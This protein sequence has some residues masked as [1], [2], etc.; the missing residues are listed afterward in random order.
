MQLLSGT[1]ADERNSLVKG[2]SSEVIPEG[3]NHPATEYKKEATDFLK[4]IIERDAEECR[5]IW[6]EEVHLFP[7]WVH[8]DDPRV[9][10]YNPQ[11]KDSA[12]E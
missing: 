10:K 4:K 9:V 5:R 12:K 2:F 3:N 1:P 8:M 7:E 11:A 6:K